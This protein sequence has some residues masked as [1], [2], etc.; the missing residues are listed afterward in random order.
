MVSVQITFTHFNIMQ[1][2]LKSG[3]NVNL[4]DI[5]FTDNQVIRSTLDTIVEK[6]I[7][8]QSNGLLAAGQDPMELIKN[9]M[10][11]NSLQDAINGVTYVQVSVSVFTV[12]S[13]VAIYQECVPEN[14]ELKR[15]VFQQMDDL[16]GNDVILAS[17]SSCIVPS[18]FT[19][20]LKHKEQCIVSHPVRMFNY[21][22]Y[23]GL[24]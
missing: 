13:A 12:V 17:S 8:L 24:V 16:I 14:V 18:K 1:L 2:F 4:Y 20:E 3:Y 6:L 7:E 11:T 10:V 19:S 5:L 22:L 23:T 9:V 21:L 15:K